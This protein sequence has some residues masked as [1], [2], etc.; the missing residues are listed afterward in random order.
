MYQRMATGNTLTVNDDGELDEDDIYVLGNANPDFSFG[1][2]NTVQYKRFSV[3]I[4]IQGVYGNEIVNFN[5]FS[6]ESFDGNQNNSTAALDRWTSENPSN[7]YPRA[8]VAARPYVLSDHQIEDGSYL[9]IKDIT[10]SYTILQ[11]C[12]SKTKVQDNLVCSFCKR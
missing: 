12:L 4:F 9:R 7:T 11:D 3:S 1:I 5:K 2:S 8:S 6:L 10:F